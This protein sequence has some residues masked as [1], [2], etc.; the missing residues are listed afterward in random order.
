MKRAIKKIKKV[1]K[2]TK[3]SVELAVPE[4]AHDSTTKS[5]HS[6]FVTGLVCILLIVVGG[7]MIRQAGDYFVGEVVQTIVIN[8]EGEKDELLATT[9]QTDSLIGVKAPAFS[10]AGNIATSTSLLSLLDKPLIVM[11]WATWQPASV[12]QL[13]AFDEYLA[14]SVE[15]SFNAVFIN[16]QE[17]DLLVRSFLRRSGYDLS[18][19]FDEVGGVGNAWQVYTVPTTYLIG[20]DGFIKEKIIGNYSVGT[21]VDKLLNINR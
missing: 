18:V 5:S 21:V 13:R 20:A 8:N 14:K 17:D 6:K 9:T 11:F 10:L 15:P 12:D 3:K 19:L 7:L 16:Y 4:P 1:I 2:P